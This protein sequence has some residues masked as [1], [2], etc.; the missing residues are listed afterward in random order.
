MNK[1]KPET[2]FGKPVEGSF[3][4]YLKQK[5]LEKSKVETPQIIQTPTIDNNLEFWTI[6][7]VN[8]RGNT[9]SYELSKNL[10][11]AKTQS[12]FASDYQTAITNNQFHSAD[13]RL[14]HA[15]FNEVYNQRNSPDS[16]EI[17]AFLNE[18][19]RNNWLTTLTRIQYQPKGK[20][21]VIHNYNTSDE[22]KLEEKIVGPDRSIEQSD[23]SALKT[24]TGMESAKLNQIYQWINN[25]NG[26]IWRVNSKPNNIE[27]RVARLNA[28]SVRFNLYCYWYPDGA[29]ASLGVRRSKKISP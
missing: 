24:L 2:M 16:E 27:E 4:I 19:L 5:E 10:L 15:I 9:Q 26:F 21:I 8:Y 22:Y 7:N 6:P 28:D 13:M 20:D 11:P 18:S 3:E 29:S 25:T 12:Q 14:Y 23:D 17:R 1:S